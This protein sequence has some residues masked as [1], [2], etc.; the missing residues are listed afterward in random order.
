VKPL[1]AIVKR[2]FLAY[3]V[4]PLAYV[5]LTAFLLINGYVFYL[6]VMALNAPETP[7]TA[8]MS[9]FFTSVF[10]WIFMMI[11]S[12]VISMRLLSEER[13]SGSIESLLT[14]PVSEGTVVV[15]KFVG[16]WCF[17]LFLWLPTVLYPVLLARHGSLDWGPI[18]SGYLGIALVGALFISAGTFASSL[19]KNQIVAAVI[20]FVII[21]AIFL[22]GIFKD[23]VTDPRFRD[24]LAYLNLLEHMEDFARGI[25]DTRRLVYVGSTVA[26]FLFLATRALDA[27]KGK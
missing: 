6:I 22:V 9:L 4:S 11:V 10:Y 5:I 23:F 2:E 15:G 8:L 12:S 7:R 19:T 26:F 16:G 21:L 18:A 24:A 25:V 3:F 1:V 13:K 17:F 27:N 14:A 20:G